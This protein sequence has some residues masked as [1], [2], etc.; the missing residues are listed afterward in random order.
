M[1]LYLC[2]HHHCV[3]GPVSGL[4]TRVVQRIKFAAQRLDLGL[5]R[6]DLAG[7]AGRAVLPPG[8][9]LYRSM[10]SAEEVKAELERALSLA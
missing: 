6:L 2:A 7:G 9:V 8:V 1:S 5:Q 4:G 10:P 3:Y